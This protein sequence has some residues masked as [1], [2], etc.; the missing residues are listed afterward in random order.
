MPPAFFRPLP[1]EEQ[2]TSYFALSVNIVN[3]SCVIIPPLYTHDEEKSNICSHYFIKFSI[4]FFCIL[5]QLKNPYPS[6]NRNA[7]KQ[8]TIGR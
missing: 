7:T 1:D 5:R 4:C 6:L 8:T 2:D 3:F